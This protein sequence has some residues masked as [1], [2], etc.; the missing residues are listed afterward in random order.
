MSRALVP[1]TLKDLGLTESINELVESMLRTQLMEIQ[2]DNAGFDE[3][4][5]PENQKLTLFR[6]VQEQLNNIIKHAEAKQ[7][8]IEL[9]NKDEIVVLQIRDDGNGFDLKKVRKGVGFVNIRNRAELFGG[10]AEIFSE[11]GKGCLLK[12]SFPQIIARP[13]IC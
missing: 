4:Q 6:I 11:P 2:F 3:D 12:V 9:N 5:M 13:I 1:S 8:W 10:E 7:V